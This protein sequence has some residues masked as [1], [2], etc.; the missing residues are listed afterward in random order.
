MGVRLSENYVSLVV[1]SVSAGAPSATLPQ[2]DTREMSS[3]G[4]NPKDCLHATIADDA[5]TGARG[6]TF[7]PINLGKWPANFQFPQYQFGWCLLA[8][9]AGDPDTRTSELN[10]YLSIF[11]EW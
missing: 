1:K 2:R 5:D 11:G 7:L 9:F 6:L 8:T 3:L 10:I 4:V